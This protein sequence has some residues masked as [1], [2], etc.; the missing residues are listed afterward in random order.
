MSGQRPQPFEVTRAKKVVWRLFDYD[1]FS[2]ISHIQL[3]DALAE[4]F[5]V[6]GS[7]AAHPPSLQHSHASA[8]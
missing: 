5:A 7:L 8:T 1:K 4:L 2:T 3:L 6:Q